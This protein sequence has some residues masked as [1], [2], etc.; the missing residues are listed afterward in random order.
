VISG[1]DAD[2]DDYTV[3]DSPSKTAAEIDSAAKDL[4]DVV[5]ECHSERSASVV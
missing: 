1:N 5:R 4:S 2:D 3:G